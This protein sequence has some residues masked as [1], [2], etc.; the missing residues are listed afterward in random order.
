LAGSDGSGWSTDF[1]AFDVRFNLLREANSAANALESE[2]Y[3]DP[4]DAVRFAHNWAHHHLQGEIQVKRHAANDGSLLGIFLP[5]VGLLRLHG[6]EELGDH[7][8]HAAKVSGAHGTFQRSGQMFHLHPGL[9]AGRVHDL[10][11]GQPHQVGASLLQQRQVA[12][13]VARI[14]SQIFVGAKLGGV[15]EDADCHA[16]AFLPGTLHQREMA[17]VQIAHGGHQAEWVG[18]R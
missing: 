17:G 9:E 13:N 3:T 4:T 14:S 16:G 10:S 18:Q 2:G 5:E 8:S 1:I 6:V 15:N 11:G 12:V 7:G